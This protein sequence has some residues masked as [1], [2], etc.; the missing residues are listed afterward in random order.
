[1]E[2]NRITVKFNFKI[3]SGLIGDLGEFIAY[4]YLS[5]EFSEKVNEVGFLIPWSATLVKVY[6]GRPHALLIPYQVIHSLQSL[7]LAVRKDRVEFNPEYRM[8]WRRGQYFLVGKDGVEIP[9]EDNSYSENLL[10]SR[11]PGTGADISFDLLSFFCNPPENIRAQLKSYP[12]IPQHCIDVNCPVLLRKLQK[13]FLERMKIGENQSENENMSQWDE[14]SPLVEEYKPTLK[15]ERDLT[16]D[17]Q[18]KVTDYF[19]FLPPGSHVSHI[20]INGEMLPLSQAIPYIL[21]DNSDGRFNQ[22]IIDYQINCEY[23]KTI[24]LIEVKTITKKTAVAFTFAETK[25]LQHIISMNFGINCSY[26][27]LIV[28]LANLIQNEFQI[29]ALDNQK[30]LAAAQNKTRISIS[31]LKLIKDI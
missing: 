11:P 9:Q 26:Q 21:S 14:I 15:N 23:L 16:V 3:P 29:S 27:V 19:H 2:R 13:I 8:V 1:M 24:Q 12:A 10:K 25:T 28:N 6:Y 7:S 18:E 22:I 20:D 5:Q 31:Y 4:R 30:I 17:E